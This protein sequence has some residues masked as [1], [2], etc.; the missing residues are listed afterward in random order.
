MAEAI[1]YIQS[2]ITNV[3]RPI[4]KESLNLRYW[5]L[6]IGHSAVNSRLFSSFSES[7]TC[8]LGP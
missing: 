1:A 2:P 4:S 3:E 8:L 5:A 7:Q 6:I